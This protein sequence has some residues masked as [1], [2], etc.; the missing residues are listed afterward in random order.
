MGANPE[1]VVVH[2]QSPLPGRASAYVQK[3]VLQDYYL[4]ESQK[5]TKVASLILKRYSVPHTEKHLVGEPGTTIAAFATGGKF[6]LVVMGSHGHG[7]LGNLM[8]GSVASKVLAKCKVPVL[9]IR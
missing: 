7:M 6:D 5:A 9:I 3:K 2:V 4:T 1:I 8:L